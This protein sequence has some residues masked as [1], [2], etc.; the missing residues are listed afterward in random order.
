VLLAQNYNRALLPAAA[1]PT[2]TAALGGDLAAAFASVPEPSAVLASC[3]GGLTL[4]GR[5]RRFPPAGL[6]DRQDNPS[7]LPKTD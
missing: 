1:D 2:V 5:R 3:V 6:R 4:M 7:R